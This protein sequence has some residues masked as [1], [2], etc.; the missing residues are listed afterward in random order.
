M[1]EDKTPT[2]ERRHFQVFVPTLVAMVV[3]VALGMAAMFYMGVKAGRGTLPVEL[4][5]EDM[6]KFLA[7]LIE[8]SSREKEIQEQ[9]SL[10]LLAEGSDVYSSLEEGTIPPPEQK[11]AP[12][13]LATTAP[14][15]APPATPTTMDAASE[16]S[17]AVEP[18][19][20]SQ[21]TDSR[22]TIQVAALTVEKDAARAAEKFI[23]KG[24]P[25]YVVSV[26]REGRPTVFRV[27]IG[28]FATRE[29]A[30]RM[31]GTLAGIRADSFIVRQ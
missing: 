16:P 4:D 13:P 12:K 21:D 15:V 6:G 17:R 23:A 26:E 5:T 9:E 8:N 2:P 24:Y 20:F 10:S 22:W 7:G 1:S 30:E 29:Q 28:R 19:P 25:A 3:L 11:P 18:P 31:H 27:R 14:A